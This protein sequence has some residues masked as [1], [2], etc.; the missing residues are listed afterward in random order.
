[1]LSPRLGVYHPDWERDE[2][3]ISMLDRTC[4]GADERRGQPY[5]VC[6]SAF[7][8]LT[9]GNAIFGFL[10]QTH[11]NQTG[12]ELRTR[13]TFSEENLKKVMAQIDFETHLQAAEVEGKKHWAQIALENAAKAKEAAAEQAHRNKL[14]EAENAA[15][16]KNEDTAYAL[17]AKYPV[18]FK[19]ACHT[20]KGYRSSSEPPGDPDLVC[21][22]MGKLP[23]LKRLKG[24]GYI[25]TNVTRLGEVDGLLF[26]GWTWQFNVE[27]YA[28]HK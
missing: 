9:A 27:R 6:N 24:A 20:P 22:N 21:Q 1:M 16:R 17:I 19:D 14:A 23:S 25:V 13:Y 18:G 4:T 26:P 28:L 2:D 5:R 10:A 3:G 11:P 8:S 12:R 7:G 15:L